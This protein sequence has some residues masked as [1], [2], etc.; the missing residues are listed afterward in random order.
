[1]NRSNDEYSPSAI[2]VVGMAG[3]FPGAPDLGHFW[4]N[5]RDGVESVRRFTEGELIAAGETPETLANPDYVN[6]C[7]VLEGADQFDAAFFGFSPQDA[8]VM[9]PQ[10]R[11]FLEVGWEALE[12]AGHESESFPGPIGV[13]ATC[14]MNSY[15]MYH[16]IQ[17]RRVMD[18]FGE[19]LVRHTGNDM[20]FLGTR[21]SY[22]LNLKGP[23]MNVQTACSSALVA[24]HL[25]C[26][27][28]LTG[29]CDMALAGGSTILLPQ[30]RGYVYK[31]SEILSPDGHCRPFD[32]KAYGTVF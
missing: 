1:M 20:S 9:D 21:L 2:A 13:F 18:T 19:W 32:A 14:G 25:A 11:V 22:E 30:N 3:R 12:E 23:S 27:S 7:P 24:I 5:L 4:R 26:Q 17:N 8:A 31:P 29:E 10:H 6:A 15:M 16:L 28:L